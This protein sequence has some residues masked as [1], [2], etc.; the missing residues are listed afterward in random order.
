MRIPCGRDLAAHT[1]TKTVR[2]SILAMCW[3]RS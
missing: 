1:I 3:G 2:I